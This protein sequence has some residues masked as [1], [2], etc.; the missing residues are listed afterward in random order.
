MPHKLKGPLLEALLDFGSIET[1]WG[2]TES[3]QNSGWS[4]DQGDNVPG[5]GAGR[6]SVQCELQSVISPRMVSVLSFGCS[7]SLLSLLFYCCFSPFHKSF[8]LP[9]LRCQG[10]L[11]FTS[12]ISFQPL[13]PLQH[14][15]RVV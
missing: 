1:S 3:A 12:I 11:E 10:C 15:K 9:E 6:A 13:G 14:V 7:F 5:A 8:R 4:W 2:N